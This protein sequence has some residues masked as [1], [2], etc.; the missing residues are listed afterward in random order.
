MSLEPAIASPRPTNSCH[1]D[2]AL[3]T[4]ATSVTDR[5]PP[6]M[7]VSDTELSQDAAAPTQQPAAGNYGG[8]LPWPVL[9]IAAAFLCTLL[10][11]VFLVWLVI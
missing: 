5:Q 2:V 6:A 10:W 7:T 11:C 8:L 3:S 4:H 9:G 1:L